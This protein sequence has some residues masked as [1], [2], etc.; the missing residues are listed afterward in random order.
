MPRFSIVI[1]TRNRAQLL[2]HALQSARAQQHDDFEIVVS[3]NACTDDSPGVVAEQHDPRLRVVHTPR[4][5][6]AHE[7]WDFATRA[8]RGD[9]LTILCDDDALH[10]AALAALQTALEAHPADLACWSFVVYHH[11]HRNPADPRNALD[12]GVY[13]NGTRVVDAPTALR[14]A[15]NLLLDDQPLLPVAIRSAWRR[16]L[17]ESLRD[18]LG[19]IFTP[20]APDYSAMALLLGAVERYLWLD[21][22][23]LIGGVAPESIGAAALANAPAFRRHVDESASPAGWTTHTPLRQHTSANGIADALLAAQSRCPALRGYELDWAM[24]YARCTQMLDL[25][26]A[27]GGDTSADREE[28]AASLRLMS[29]D[30]TQRVAR[31]RDRLAAAP[32][33]C[34]DDAPTGSAV[35]PSRAPFYVPPLIGRDERFAD[36][37]ECAAVLADPDNL[38][39]LEAVGE[40]IVRHARRDAG[41]ERLILYGFGRHG[42]AILP[43]LRRRLAANVA[44]TWF[45]DHAPQSPAAGSVAE[46]PTRTDQWRRTFV[47]VTP[48]Q[49]EALRTRLA[50]GGGVEG[51]NWTTWRRVVHDARASARTRRAPSNAI[52]RELESFA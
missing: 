23:L 28:L 3:L 32:R 9:Y 29:P 41:L 11:P 8:A 6:A 33:A 47:L 39:S 12:G 50:S 1:P 16:S 24:Y 48:W 49:D 18:Q 5:L 31:C 21:A 13:S 7:H 44:L 37:A 25:R 17:Q 20:T 43:I 42:R 36:I 46:L 19:N 27:C 14:A 4:P 15:Y 22:P 2:R 10:P 51:T 38:V 45:D 40:Q 52:P 34:D 26:D 30:I 35:L